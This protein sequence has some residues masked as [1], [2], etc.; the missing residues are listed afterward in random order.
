MEV[1][2]CGG[3]VMWGNFLSFNLKINIVMKMLLTVL[4]Y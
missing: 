3:D 1:M 4:Y 2:S